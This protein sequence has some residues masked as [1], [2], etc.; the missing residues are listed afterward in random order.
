MT[1][2][3]DFSVTIPS[4][5]KYLSKIDR[6]I[7][8]FREEDAS[9]YL[10]HKKILVD[11]ERSVQRA[12]K[13]LNYLHDMAVELS[14]NVSSFANHKWL[15]EVCPVCDKPRDDHR[16]SGFEMCEPEDD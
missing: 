5:S 16:Y 15:S 3:I 2:Q 6:E 12:I 8:K 11:L 13:L 1:N 7:E 10:E 9:T 14:A 4:F